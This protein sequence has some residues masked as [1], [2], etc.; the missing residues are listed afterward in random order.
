MLNWRAHWPK[1]LFFVTLCFGLFSLGISYV[2]EGRES[3][4]AY[5]TQILDNSLLEYE[6]IVNALPELKSD[7]AETT[8]M[9][10]PVTAQ[11]CNNNMIGRRS[12]SLETK[13]V[14]QEIQQPQVSDPAVQRE[15]DVAKSKMTE[16][17][18]DAK[19]PNQT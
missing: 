11:S 13:L 9:S 6:N 2:K 14:E 3:S 18:T 15:L 17:S 1:W 19:N 10:F 7:A 4:L 5:N 16:L 8:F 12:C